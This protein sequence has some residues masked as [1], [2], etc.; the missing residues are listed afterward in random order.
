[1][2]VGL[3]EESMSARVDGG[4][5]D[6]GHAGSFRALGTKSGWMVMAAV[7]DE[8]GIDVEVAGGVAEEV[9][10]TGAGEDVAV[11]QGAGVGGS[12]GSRVA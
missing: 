10:G 5:G 11:V 6:W 9:D 7:G 12:S 8:I 4:V 3:G 2:V 1:M